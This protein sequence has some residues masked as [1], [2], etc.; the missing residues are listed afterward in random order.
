MRCFSNNFIG[1]LK[2]ILS[3]PEGLEED[4]EL[5]WCYR[6]LEKDLEELKREGWVRTI[7][8]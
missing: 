8:Y 5:K 4:E 6:D 3:N 1:L 7:K 2:L